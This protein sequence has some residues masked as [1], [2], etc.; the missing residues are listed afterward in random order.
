[1]CAC[2][3]LR[4]FLES[5]GTHAAAGAGGIT[6]AISE[7]TRKLDWDTRTVTEK[8][9]TRRRQGAGLYCNKSETVIGN[10]ISLESARLT[11]NDTCRET[12]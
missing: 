10:L 8:L 1:M 4:A 2:V 7:R 11:R 9:P 12:P 5:Y 6:V 3:E